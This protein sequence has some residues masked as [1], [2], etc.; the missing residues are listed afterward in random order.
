M[1][2]SAT[3]PPKFFT[4]ILL[5]ALSVAS[6]NFFVTSLSNMAEE[7][8]T[9][10]AVVNLAIAGYA[11][12]TAVL[13][14][15]IGPLSDRLGRR[16]I[17]IAG[18]IIFILASMGCLLAEDIS[19]FLFFRLLQ[20]AIVSGSV[21][22]NAVVRDMLP[23][24]EAASK[25]GY[26]AMAWAVAPMLGPMLGGVLDELFGWR[27]SFIVFF[28]LGV[29][30]LSLCW[31]DLG[32]TNKNPSETFAKQFK[33]YPELFRSRRF[34]GYALCMAFSA[35]AFYAFL[36][37]VPLV[38]K[39]VFGMSATSLGFYIGTITAGF[40]L[41][42]FLSGRFARYYQLTTMM[43][44][45]RIVACVGLV[46]G[47]GLFLTGVVHVFSLFGACMFVGIGNGLTMP[48]SSAGAMSVRPRLAGSASGLSGALTV[49]GG[50][51]MASITGI[52]VTEQNGIYP[53]L[54]TMLFS[55]LMGLIAALYV[56]WVDRSEEA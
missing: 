13:L 38:A 1:F 49:G 15:I 20:G 53:L 8:Q 45:G 7:F 12:M 51:V 18:L 5:S 4:L 17:I 47:L 37:G 56:L 11:G 41:G 30:L 50:A 2:Y 9:D 23:A 28:G 32:E 3:T 55:S 26:L 14:L 10:Y 31:I 6:L 52:L 42:S 24:R 27:A 21:L 54:G 33:D 36:G 29:V 25:L 19:T 34:W 16:P 22:S 46:L 40:L 48:S 39:T 35:G 44:M 43:I